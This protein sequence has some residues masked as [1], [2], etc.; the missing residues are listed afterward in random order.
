MA[1][2][3]AAA[4]RRSPGSR[5]PWGGRCGRA[6]GCAVVQEGQRAGR[7]YFGNLRV[8]MIVDGVAAPEDADA[9]IG[10]ATRELEARGMEILVSNQMNPAWRAALRHAGFIRGPSN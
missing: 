10:L 1:S 3:W 5:A 8:G 2:A 7:K 4:T 6:L 9:V